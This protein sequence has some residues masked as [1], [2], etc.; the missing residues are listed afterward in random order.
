MSKDWLSRITTEELAKG[1]QAFRYPEQAAMYYKVKDLVLENDLRFIDTQIKESSD[2]YT[3]IASLYPK[4]FPVMQ[5]F[6]NWCYDNKENGDTLSW[7]EFRDFFVPKLPK[8]S[9]FLYDYIYSSTS[10]HTNK[11]VFSHQKQT[12]ESLLKSIWRTPS[13]VTS[14]CNTDCFGIAGIVDDSTGSYT[15]LVDQ[16]RM[17]YMIFSPEGY[18]SAVDE[19]E[20]IT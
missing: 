19:C 5:E 15:E 3:A 18:P 7:K 6:V 16:N 2:Y 14:P 11:Q 8:G 20:L 12:F 13:I 17:P 1:S 10:V 4:R 9:Y